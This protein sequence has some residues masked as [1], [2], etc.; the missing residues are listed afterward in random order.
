VCSLW[1]DATTCV[2]LGDIM[3]YG[4]SSGELCFIE[5]KSGRVNSAILEPVGQP[6]T[7]QIFAQLDALAEKYREHAIA[8]L[9]RVL[10]QETEQPGHPPHA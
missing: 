6:P 10:R 3:K 5:L 4:A 9:G 2:D 1:N 7:D 8:Q